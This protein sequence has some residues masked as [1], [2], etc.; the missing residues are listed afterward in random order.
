LQVAGI[1][2]Y[3]RKKVI[4]VQLCKKGIVFSKNDSHRYKVQENKL[5]W[6]YK[7]SQV[8]AEEV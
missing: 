4:E 5:S 1:S 8:Q 3:R 2:I 6:H 7:L